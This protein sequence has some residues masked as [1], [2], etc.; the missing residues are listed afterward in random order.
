MDQRYRPDMD[1]GEKLYAEGDIDAAAGVF[2]SIVAQKPDHEDALNNLGVISFQKGD[3]KTAENLFLKSLSANDQNQ[4]AVS[5]LI[6]LYESTRQKGKAD[7]LRRQQSHPGPI[8]TTPSVS[9]DAASATADLRNDDPAYFRAAFREVNITPELSDQRPV[10]MQ[11]IAMFPRHASATAA[12]LKMQM[13]LL[14]D[15]DYTKLLIVTADL[16]GFSS[17]TAD[18]VRQ[19]AA[20]WGIDPAAVILNASHTHNAPG[21]VPFMPRILGPCY[22]EYVRH[23][24]SVIQ[25]SI[26]H[27]YACL[28]P[29]R[30]SWSWARAQIGVNRRLKKDDHI[31]FAPNPGGFYD[32]YTPFLLVE[33]L[34]KGRR[35]IMARHS[36]HPTGS[37]SE[38]VI[39][40]DY[41]GYFREA[42]MCQTGIDGVMFLQG[43]AGSSKLADDT[44][45]LQDFAESSGA[46][47][48]AGKRL[49]RAV[50]DKLVW[51]LQPVTGS[52]HASM[53]TQH[54][55]L[56]PH[57]GKEKILQL[58][59]AT[60]ANPLVRDWAKLMIQRYPAAAYPTRL[61]LAF[62]AVHLGREVA[63]LTVPAEPTAELSREMHSTAD[64]DKA[65]F[66]LGY[67]NG[68]SGYLA[69]PEMMNEGG[70]ECDLSHVVYG[71]PSKTAGNVVPLLR[72]FQDKTTAAMREKHPVNAAG[73]PRNAQSR[74]GRAFFVLS[75]GRCGT[76]TLAHMLDTATNA[77]VF[78]HPQPDP[79]R[80]C[81]Q[82]WWGK[83]EKSE[84]FWRFRRPFLTQAWKM[85][86]V[87]GE[88]DL[89][90][91]PFSEAIAREIPEAKFIALIRD[92]RD[93][94]RS[95]MR[96]NYYRGH[97][98]DVG[99]LRPAVGDEDSPVWDRMSPF[100]KVC[101]LWARTYREIGAMAERIGAERVRILRMEDLVRRP[102]TVKD[103]FAFLGLNGYDEVTIRKIRSQ[104]FNAQTQGEFPK[105]KQ[106]TDED[107]ET[108]WRICGPVAEQYG[109]SRIYA[110]ASRKASSAPETD[111]AS[112][113]AS[114]GIVR[115][116]TQKEAPPA[117]PAQGNPHS[118][119]GFIAEG[120]VITC[121]LKM[122]RF[123]NIMGP[124]VIKGNRACS[125]GNYCALG[126][127]IHIITSHHDISRPNMQVAMQNRHGFRG[128]WTSRG[129]VRIG[130]NVWIG[131]NAVIL[132]GVT[133]GDGAVIGAGAVVMNDVPPFSVA[134]G[135]PA[136]V[137][138]LRFSQRIIRQ[139]LDIRWWDW[140]EE[141]IARNRI[142]FEMDLTEDP[143]LDLNRIILP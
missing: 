43:A 3:T 45:S 81:L 143:N 28:E 112:E 44:R 90:M 129:E 32:T 139:L 106:W 48:A 127:G 108:L 38:S 13:M 119:S 51:P 110:S 94:V 85:G 67:T 12:P 10:L 52:I 59:D 109:Y 69:T 73:E 118:S 74:T 23:I 47:E 122:G 64:S 134:A 84:A 22:P 114:P 41:P 27:L 14:E 17:E 18:A 1:M 63:F 111:G 53:E 58:A 124:A 102:E 31:E 92:P 140:P 130:N 65:L 142:F 46:T 54:L 4:D 100:E 16:F 36:C 20:Q 34:D 135:N 107:H 6:R 105:P 103:V 116:D 26:A 8:R 40:A 50:A 25:Q 95:G 80:E 113:G 104:K 42:L 79:I 99:R 97:P 30:L 131:D 88:T 83:I 2:Q 91:T 137:V 5:N 101:W 71:L 76:M 49:A 19:L 60:D 11:G 133:V 89:L 126:W 57:P 62:Q 136:H 120:S 123:S 132:S 128:I 55:E 115:A 98:W 56:A 86:L 87:H 68:L 7:A 66:F 35:I 121:P 33:F 29:V 78:H 138:K 39:S 117:S 72:R 15:R 70:Y 75:A 82:A 24:T 141:R 77:R 96:R 125:I 9:D 93:F 21:T 61:S 37:S